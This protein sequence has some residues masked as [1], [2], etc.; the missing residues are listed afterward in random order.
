MSVKKLKLQ[1]LAIWMIII[2]M[3]ISIIYF[4]LFAS[5]RYVSNAQIVVRQAESGQQA[6][7][8]GLALLMGS[9]D[10][11]SREY[12]LYLRE[13]ILSH[14]MLLYLEDVA[15]WTEHY[16]G[17]ILDPLYWLNHS[18]PLEKKLKYYQKMVGATYD[19]TTGLLKIDVQAFSPEYSQ[20]VLQEILK[21]SE[22]FVNAISRDMAL[23]QL[24]FARK[25]LLAST[26]RYE[27]SKNRMLAFQNRYKLLDAEATA[28]SMV[29]IVSTLEAE[30]AKE[31]AKLK[32]LVATLA[33][34]A[35]Q[36]RAQT[37]KIKALEEQL[38]SEKGRITSLE[39]LDDPLNV[40]AS[41]YRKLQVDTLV[42]E[43]FYKTS[44]AVVENAKLETTK[45]LRNLVAVVEPNLPEYP[46]YPRHL[47]NLITIFI[48]LCLLY[49]ITR[50]VIA[51]IEDHRE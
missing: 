32:A 46:L 29:G 51:S 48:A 17:H 40:I 49:G 7:M 6:S 19:E 39:S 3:V 13:H 1:P 43:E 44:L 5:N 20:K 25:E 22:V 4:S 27:A 16:S 12:T 11:A 30:I 42:A 35:P 2:P 45:N 31:N 36:I 23:E 34:D 15:D 18:A 26:E 41:E 14:D 28:V 10:P 37:N 24:E 8:P 50:F 47:Y 33:T 21:S 9:A 38:A